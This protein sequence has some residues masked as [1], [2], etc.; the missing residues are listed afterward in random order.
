MEVLGQCTT[1]NSYPRCCGPM[2]SM[3]KSCGPARI[4]SKVRPQDP[5]GGAAR[6]AVPRKAVDMETRSSS[7]SS[8]VEPQSVSSRIL[9]VL[10]EETK[11]RGAECLAFL[12]VDKALCLLAGA[13]CPASVT[14]CENC[15]YDARCC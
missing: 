3:G 8:V 7:V 5:G 4:S 12:P 2:P 6:I 15:I 14:V 9:V 10:V 1:G 11:V 13:A